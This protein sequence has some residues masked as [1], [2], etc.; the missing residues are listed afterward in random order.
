MPT[1]PDHT[2]TQLVRDLISRRSEGVYWDF[3]L[4]HHCNTDDLIHDVL[5]LANADHEGPRYLIFGVKDGGGSVQTIKDDE[6]RRSQSDIAGL[7]RDNASKFFQSRFPTFHLRT[8][9]IFDEQVD[10]LV[11]EDE[12][13]KPYYLV[14]NIKQVRAHHI[15]TRVCDT[16]TPVNDV[17][18]PHEIIR[19][20]RQQFGLDASALKRVKRYL[21]EPASW[22]AVDE[23]GFAC[24]H[25]DVFPE[26]TLKA[27]DVEEIFQV[28][29]QEWTQ[30]EIRTDDNHTGSY[31]LRFHQTLLRRIL[32]VSF[33]NHKKSVVAP[34][35]EPIG[36]GRLYYYQADSIRYAVQRF[37]TAHDSSDDSRGLQIRGRSESAN[38]ARSRWNG[39]LD[40]PVLKPGELEGFLEQC[41]VKTSGFIMPATDPVEQYELFLRNL[42]DF[43]KWRR[44]QGHGYGEIA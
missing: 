18:Q 42:L 29:T 22:T 17:A 6:G 36:Q 39:R 37:W 30:G 44:N 13:K 4:K 9:E 19:M 35:W 40:I 34:D 5:C 26:F 32:Y 21:A 27:A 3:K 2:L 11:I 43:D 41:Q 16:N 23:G 12:P 28:H 14:K 10:V 25:H 7:F 33:D 31:E 1:I 24:W 8:I 15:Y 38:E 20:W